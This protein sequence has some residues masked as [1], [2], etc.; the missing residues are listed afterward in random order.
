VDN[1][2]NSLQPHQTLEVD[3]VVPRPTFAY[4]CPGSSTSWTAC[5][6]PHLHQ[7]WTNP[8]LPQ[9]YAAYALPEEWIHATTA[10]FRPP[11]LHPL[12]NYLTGTESHA[13]AAD[14]ADIVEVVYLA[15]CLLA[16]DR[17]VHRRYVPEANAPCRQ[18]CERIVDLARRSAAASSGYASA[19][20]ARHEALWAITLFLMYVVPRHPGQLPIILEMLDAIGPKP[21]WQTHSEL[22][23][24]F[25]SKV[26]EA[27][28]H[29]PP[30]LRVFSVTEPREPHRDVQMMLKLIPNITCLSASRLL[31]VFPALI[32]AL[33]LAVTSFVPIVWMHYKHGRIQA[34]V[35]LLDQTSELCP[36]RGQL[37]PEH[38]IHYLYG[39]SQICDCP[40]MR[41]YRRFMLFLGRMIRA[42]DLLRPATFMIRIMKGIPAHLQFLLAEQS[43]DRKG[44]PLCKG[45]V[46]ADL[47]QTALI[48][49]R[50][51]TPRLLD[52]LK[53][54]IDGYEGWFREKGLENVR[55]MFDQHLGI[56]CAIEPLPLP[57][58]VKPVSWMDSRGGV[59]TSCGQPDVDLDI[60]QRRLDAV[61]F[62]EFLTGILFMEGSAVQNY[63]LAMLCD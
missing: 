58:G 33:S 41:F 38:A 37:L 15:M 13:T 51:Y 17:P 2:L 4:C 60:L 48:S 1:P 22:F 5:Y 12:M 43:G 44:C 8:F 49:L 46:P 62:D 52:H 24:H 45:F 35:S 16:T 55:E 28:M 29:L 7:V 56:N 9:K 31:S 42:K 20:H 19:T 59:F 32:G 27:L 53:Q 3:N 61:A 54:I 23:L 18:A 39:E 50:Q 10:A 57:P 40:L 21:F 63:R 11:Q 6:V 14:F 25:F 26:R 34:S 30:E 36:V 47:I